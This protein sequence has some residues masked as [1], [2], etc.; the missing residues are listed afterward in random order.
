MTHIN[1]TVLVTTFAI[2]CLSLMASTSALKAESVPKDLLGFWSLD[3]ESGEPAWMRVAE[4]EGRPVVQMRIYIGPDGPYEVA[5]VTNGRIKFSLKPERKSN[6]SKV[7]TQRNVEVGLT[8]GKLDGVLVR[9]PNDGR[10]GQEIRFTGK[11]VPPMTKSAPDLSKVRFGHPIS[12]FNGKDL[13]GW[14][15]YESDKING[16]SAQDGMLVN[17]TT[18]TDFSP[19]GSHANLRTEAEFEDF[20]LHIEF[21]VEADRNSGIYLRGMYEAQVVDR[22]SRMQGLQGVGAIFGRIAP[23][24]QAGN[25]GGQW[26]TYD[27][28]LVDRHVTVV[29][30][31]TKVIDNQPIDG[32]TA[33][34]IKTDPSSSGP[35]YLQG[36]HTAVKFKNI[37]LAPVVSAE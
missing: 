19:T 17:T 37:Y 1:R 15:P 22:D 13:T 7:Y 36:D 26:Q 24:A 16:W 10:E 32:P 2:S 23:S 9:T 35:I 29:L 3:L 6:G 18:K 21:L 5:E 8:K 27:I 12:L 30:N 4:E 25:P 34:A 11:R 33:G 14:R 28:T 31:G 20:W